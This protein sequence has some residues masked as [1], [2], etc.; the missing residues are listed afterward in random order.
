MQQ[1]PF[2][3]S[4]HDSLGRVG[5]MVQQYP[6]KKMSTSTLSGLT[7]RSKR[8]ASK[9][10]RCNSTINMETGDPDVHN[11]VPIFGQPSQNNGIAVVALINTNLVTKDNPLH[12]ITGSITILL[13]Q[14]ATQQ[15]EIPMLGRARLDQVPQGVATPPLC[16]KVSGC[17]SVYHK[18]KW[19]LLQ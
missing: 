6:T 17:I 10:R 7:S 5:D 19:K 3:R 11:S 8:C 13:R 15:V 4:I 14:D 9:K 12:E 1:P 18:P 16:N 2:P